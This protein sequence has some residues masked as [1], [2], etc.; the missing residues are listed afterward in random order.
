MRMAAVYKAIVFL[1]HEVT[2]TLVHK[3]TFP[4]IRIKLMRPTTSTSKKH[5]KVYRVS[6]NYQEATAHL[7]A[8]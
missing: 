1:V 5:Q 4:T 7:T 2:H 8:W 3:T 6:Q